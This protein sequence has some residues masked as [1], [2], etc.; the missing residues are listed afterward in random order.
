M[1][2][3]ASNETVK[4]YIDPKTGKIADEETELWVEVLKELPVSVAKILQESF[5]KPRVEVGED[6][7]QHIILEDMETLPIDFLARV[8]MNWSEKEP[9]NPQNVAKMRVDIARAIYN[10]LQEMYAISQQ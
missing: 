6:G 4:I 1:G 9:V 2:L 10:K 8:I 3:L 7:K 5:G